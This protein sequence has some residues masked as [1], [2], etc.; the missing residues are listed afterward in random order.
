[1]NAHFISPVFFTMSRLIFLAFILLAAP[2]LH[3]QD[4]DLE[5][6]IT[7]AKPAILLGEPAFI[8]VSA[9]NRS[10]HALAIDW[11]T[12]CCGAHEFIAEVPAATPGSS[13]PKFCGGM[14]CSCA[15]GMEPVLEVGE[16]QTHRYVLQ[17]DFRIT[18]PGR[19]EVIIHKPM[20]HA[21]AP[22]KPTIFFPPANP[23]QTVD[24]KLSLEVLPAD[25]AKLLAIEQTLAA[26]AATPN[27]TL[28]YPAIQGLSDDARDKAFRDFD[29]QRR[30]RDQLANLNRYAIYEA[31][32]KFPTP[33]MEPIFIDW[34]TPPHSIGHG[35]DALKHLNT[36]AA[37]AA[38][39]RWA[40]ADSHAPLPPHTD[41]PQAQHAAELSAQYH[42][43]AAAGA[44]AEMGD[45][46]YIPLLETLANDPSEYV[47]QQAVLGLG[48][49]GG[50]DV[51]P[52]LVKYAHQ[53]MSMHDRQQ[54]IMS[55]GRTASVKA[56][57][58]IIDLFMLP[59]ADQPNASDYALY[60]LTHHRTT[61][62][63]SEAAQ[64]A[65]RA[66]L[67]SNPNPPI[68]GQYDCESSHP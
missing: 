9:T 36:P 68:F 15:R 41:T 43:A 39:A 45:R 57:P 50:E 59:D 54:A 67:S 14:A 30:K 63:T 48:Q 66:W 31:L 52:F 12:S 10:T 1:M 33:G 7:L 2:T 16:T 20:P 55:L 27:P 62:R 22:A 42:R 61:A 64:S 26:E 35:I 4:H 65:W 58:H 24:A 18:H 56:V 47:R 23:A 3:A 17:G 51:I 38:L 19:Y 40:T 34:E 37:R 21:T 49:L 6:H 5:V 46:S 53:A 28:P 44:F 8:V 29:N 25:P 11:G 13:E 60:T 32:S